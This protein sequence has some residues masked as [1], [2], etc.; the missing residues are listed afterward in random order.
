[1]GAELGFLYND[2]YAEILGIK[3]P[4]AMGGRFR[5]IWSEIWPDIEPLI[6][7][8]LAG[9]ATFH[10][11]LPLAMRRRGFDE[12]T[13]FTFSYSPVHD[14]TGGV[15][16][17]FCA[18]TETTQEVERRAALQDDR[19]HL[20]RLFQQAPSM[21]CI[22]SGPEHIFVLANPIYL[23]FIGNRD[24]IGRKLREAVPNWKVRAS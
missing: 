11:D 3:H 21:V 16:G 10:E 18:C 17:M 14:E 9:E 2:G 5:D 13:Y 8:A 12:Q 24:V 6:N 20:H 4:A 19:E 7:K 23:E 22:L 1:M 15:G